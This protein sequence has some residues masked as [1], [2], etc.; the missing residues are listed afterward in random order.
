[1]L[2]PLAR[3]EASSDN[4][5]EYLV[6]VGLQLATRSQSLVSVTLFRIMSSQAAQFPEIPRLVSEVGRDPIKRKVAAVL[7][8]HATHLRTADLDAA[9]DIYVALTT[10]SVLAQAMMGIVT[11]PDRME[12]H[13]RAVL[14]VFL[15][16]VLRR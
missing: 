2:E 4:L 3:I 13:I 6:S 10:D 15:R 7:A 1:V 5:E 14:D 11:P 8:R 9:A 16:G 12:A